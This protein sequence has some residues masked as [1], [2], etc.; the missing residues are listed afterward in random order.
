MSQFRQDLLDAA[1][2]LS[3]QYDQIKNEAQRRLGSL[4]NPADYPT[5]L[6]G[7]F[8]LEVSYPAVE[9]PPYLLALT[10]TNQTQSGPCADLPTY[11]YRFPSLLAIMNAPT[12]PKT[13]APRGC[14]AP[15]SLAW[16]A[17]I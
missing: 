11:R 3:S 9:P 2:E 15:V 4:F 14:L 8:D 10:P 12:R 17:I 16:S 7:M 1:R 13:T 6:D 5:T